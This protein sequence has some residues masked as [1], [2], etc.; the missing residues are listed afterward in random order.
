MSARS[1]RP[2]RRAFLRVGGLVVAGPALLAAC[3]DESGD[4]VAPTFT[5][6]TT[7]APP[8]TT[9]G[10]E[11]DLVL[12]NTAISLEILAIDTYQAALDTGL[13]ESASLVA[14]ARRIQGHHTEHRDALVA[15]VQLAGA[16]PYRTANA[17]VKAGFTDPALYSASSEGDLVRLAYDIEHM[18]ARMYVHA[19]TVLSSPELRQRAL[20]IGSVAQRHATVLE[21]IGD[22]RNDKPA[23]LPATNPLPSDARI[24]G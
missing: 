5:T 23:V 17:V 11:T 24:T 7:T 8:G 20:S 19:A 14:A 10:P 22:L 4:R 3:G 1:G 21:L 18:A 13:V 12:V 9:P 16:E 2:D 15:V 6:T